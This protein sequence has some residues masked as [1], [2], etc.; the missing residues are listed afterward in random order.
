VGLMLTQ[1]GPKVLE[2]NVRMGD[3]E[4]QPVLLRLKSDWVEICEAVLAGQLDQK[5]LEWDDGCAVCVVLVSGGYPGAYVSGKKI[6]G[7]DTVAALPGVKVFH[8]GTRADDGSLLTAGG[9]V[10]GVTAK[11]DFLAEAIGRAYQAT[12]RIAFEQMHFRRDI[13]V[14]GL[15]MASSMVLPGDST[16][17]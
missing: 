16:H 14:K 11:G 4:T 13:G 5:T 10:L 8:A 3:P 6:T 7:L 2:F 1:E 12:A 9:R 17:R 15:K